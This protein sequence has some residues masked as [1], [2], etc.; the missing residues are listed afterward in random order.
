MNIGILKEDPRHERRIALTPAAVESLIVLGNSVYVEKDAGIASH[1]SDEDYKSVGASVVYT[2]DEV[3]GRS[4]L[5]LKISSPTI[6]QCERLING[7]MLCS[8]LHLPVANPRI[9]GSLLRK[10]I[11][12]I[13]YELMEDPSGN[14][15]VLRAM[16]EIAGQMTIQ[17]AARYLESRN[18]GRG[19]VLGGITGVQPGLVV[20]LGG[21]TVGQ[22]AAET[23]LGIGANVIVF[24]KDLER[25]RWIR[26][27][28]PNRVTTSVTSAYNLSKAL[29]NTDV[30]IGA[31]MNKGERA[32]HVVN[33]EMVKHMKPGSIIID[34]AIDQ[35][36]CIETSR[37][38]TLE[39][40][41]YTLHD[42][43][44]Y[45]VP[46]MAANV[47]RTATYGLTNSL[48]PFLMEIV[49]KGIHKAMTENAGLRAGVCTIDGQRTKNILNPA[50][51]TEPS[52][53]EP[54]SFSK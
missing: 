35:G 13:G 8:F 32:P 29:R 7:Q 33:E 4:N 52:F 53:V 11:C 3:Y 19:I 23:A 45:C 44:H 20:I 40:P 38:T 54:L 48:L 16:S 34:V 43:I 28:F 26:N 10:K 46:N 15:P 5:L 1:F 39:N 51:E 2:P 24:D 17:V 47:A 14:L 27:R 22:A 18:N 31:I 41:T 21:G 25:L 12:S 9:I 49:Q 42:V 37:P 30:L 36:G 50:V 6:E